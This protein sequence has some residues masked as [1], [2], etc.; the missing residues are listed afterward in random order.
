M[1]INCANYCR[2]WLEFLLFSISCISGWVE[3]M[4][5]EFKWINY[6]R[7]AL[8]YCLFLQSNE[9]MNQSDTTSSE[10]KMN[11]SRIKKML[12]TWNKPLWIERLN[13]LSRV[14]FHLCGHRLNE[15]K[16][17]CWNEIIFLKATKKFWLL[18]KP[19]K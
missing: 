7:I 9:S 4:Q 18:L 16:Q 19:Q 10:L 11:K 6:S 13:P 5:H 14:S 17:H 8:R 2:N 15:N 12:E 3:R 1:S